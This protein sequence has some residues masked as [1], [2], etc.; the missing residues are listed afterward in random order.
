MIKVFQDFSEVEDIWESLVPKSQTATLFQTFEW[1]KN[2]WEHFGKGKI[3]LLEIKEGEELIG[4]A[5]F[6]EKDGVLNFLGTNKVLGRELVTDY[7]DIVAKRG[8]EEGC[9]RKILEFFKIPKDFHFIREESQSLEVLG[10][11]GGKV[12]VEDRAPYID[13]PSTWEEYLMSLS[14]KS[15]H[16]L[17]RKMRKFETAGLSQTCLS[18]NYHGDITEFFALFKQTSGEKR[19]FLTTQMSD[20]LKSLG[21]IFLPR[22]ILEL[23]FL[24]L[25]GKKTAAT[26]SF[27]F[28][29]ETLLYNSGFDQEFT[30]LVP[31]LILKAQLIKRAIEEGR[32]RFDFLRG[33]ERYKYDLG[34]KDQKLYRIRL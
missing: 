22:G 15:R 7:G 1:Q 20:F 21:E 19:E 9:W 34:G 28:K 14:R 3:W 17:R 24:E 33:K 6:E 18:Q 8:K 32:S 4:L 12:E 30:S 13:L 27:V 5:S 26:L 11:L 16:E 29:N 2:W 10:K 23:C 31:G 25:E